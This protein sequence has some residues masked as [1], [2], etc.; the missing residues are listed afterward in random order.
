VPV[1]R[2]LKAK[3]VSHYVMTFLKD[4]YALKIRTFVSELFSWASQ[5][6]CFVLWC[7]SL[8]KYL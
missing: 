6:A 8:R 3:P 4:L 2:K 1:T 5:M 7:V